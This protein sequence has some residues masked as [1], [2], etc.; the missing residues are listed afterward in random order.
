MHSFHNDPAL[1]SGGAYASPIM[2]ERQAGLRRG[3]FPD[4]RE[5]T[6]KCTADHQHGPSVFAESSGGIIDQHIF[7]ADVVGGN[8]PVGGLPC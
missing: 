2:R 4:L 6:G 5:V 8:D 1:P 7:Y 3:S